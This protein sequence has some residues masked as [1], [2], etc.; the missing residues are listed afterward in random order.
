MPIAFIVD[1][2]GAFKGL[3]T[4]RDIIE[5]IL[6]NIPSDHN[7]DQPLV[8]QQENGSFLLD[9]MLPIEEL[10]SVLQVEDLLES[11]DEDDYY[12]LAGF[13]IT[14]LGKIPLTLDTFIF[15][16]WNFEILKMD[17]N[18]IDKVL[19]TPIDKTIATE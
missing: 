4:L 12:T 15:H 8:T 9:G 11:D 16:N 13:I 17:G 1:E 6:G 18:R 5:A 3:I 7:H 19:I 10:K 14:F 2:Y